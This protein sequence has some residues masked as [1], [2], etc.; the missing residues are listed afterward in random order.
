MT[1]Q[2][3][4]AADKAAVQKYHN[5]YAGVPDKL[6]VPLW[7]QWVAMA[8]ADA[9][10]GSGADWSKVS[11]ELIKQAHEKG[12]DLSFLISTGLRKGETAAQL[13]ERFIAWAQSWIA[14]AADKPFATVSKSSSHG[15]LVGALI[16]AG[17][18]Y[19]LTRKRG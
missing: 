11:D 4:V 8:K 14:A 19:H 3:Q 6:R 13:S 16:V 10:N 7:V 9:Q 5:F 12:E 17:L 1:E 18:F 2:E 15:L